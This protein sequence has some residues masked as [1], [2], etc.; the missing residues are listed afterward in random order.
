MYALQD[1]PKDEVVMPTQMIA[2]VD[3]DVSTDYEEDCNPLE[4]IEVCKVWFRLH[5]SVSSVSYGCGVEEAWAKSSTRRAC[6]S[7]MLR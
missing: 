5:G 1:S 6:C 3:E 2:T 7:S 4:Q